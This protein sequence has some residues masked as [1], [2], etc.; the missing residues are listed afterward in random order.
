MKENAILRAL[1][2]P[3]VC[4]KG[5]G[6]RACRSLRSLRDEPLRIISPGAPD[7]ARKAAVDLTASKVVPRNGRFVFV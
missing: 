6:A 7:K 5:G 2:E 4:C 3:P 1:R